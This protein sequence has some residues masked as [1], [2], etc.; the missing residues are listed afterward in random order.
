MY[1]THQLF[2]LHKAQTVHITRFYYIF[3]LHLFQLKQVCVQ[4]P[5]YAD[6]VALP[7][8]GCHCCSM[9]RYLLPT[10]PTAAN[11]QPVGMLQSAVGPRWNRRMETTYYTGSAKNSHVFKWLPLKFPLLAHNIS[12][13]RQYHSHQHSRKLK[14]SNNRNQS[15]R[16][17][18]K[19]L[20]YCKTDRASTLVVNRCNWT[21]W[22]YILQEALHRCQSK[23]WTSLHRSSSTGSQRW[24]CLLMSS[25][26]GGR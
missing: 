7:A 17:S 20:N 19:Q 4:L 22:F 15:Y 18:N 11:R 5:T 23:S 24:R 8:F 10:R 9:D 12:G 6:N 1:D 26:A 14:T 13:Q 25:G 16:H 3:A 21:V 2:N